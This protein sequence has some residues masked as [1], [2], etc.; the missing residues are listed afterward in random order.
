MC[1]VARSGEAAT[2]RA[3]VRLVAQPSN[4]PTARQFVHRALTDWG[5]H[6]V[7]EDVELC[8]SEL[9]TNAALHSGSVWLEV[10]LEQRPSAVQVSVADTG[11][12][13]VDLLAAQPQLRDPALKDR[14]VDDAATTG[15]GMFLVSVLASAWG[16]E[17]LP[18]GKRVWADFDRS[19]SDAHDGEPLDAEVTRSPDRRTRTLDPSE[20]AVVRFR[21][22]PAALLLAHDDNLAEYTRE[23]QL[24]GDRLGEPSFRTLSSVLAGYVA[25][26]ATNWDPA[27][28]VAHE[29]VRQ[30]Q[31]LVDIDVVAST[32]VRASIR[33][34]RGLIAEVEALSRRGVLM[35]LPADEPVQQLRDWFEGEFLAQIEDGA[36]PLPYPDWL[37]G[38]RR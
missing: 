29:A 7:A 24:I 34:L 5:C 8:V 3:Q 38:A 16:I 25:D 11:M 35:T 20:W 28:I 12:G 18:V 21:G 22:C 10:A 30:G 36:E 2:T 6:A 15:R 32:E 4:V 19:A 31:E 27:R 14:S 33:F 17:E 13:P 9:A 1:R 37:A 23:L 26:H